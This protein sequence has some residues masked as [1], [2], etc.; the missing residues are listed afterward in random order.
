MRDDFWKN[1]SVLI[2]GHT[3]F[4]GA[5]LSL[6]LN[7]LGAN[8]SGYATEPP[9]NPSLFELASVGI[10]TQSTIADIRDSASLEGVFKSNQPEIV[11]HLAAQSLVRPSYKDPVETFTTNVIGTVNVLE[12]IRN[13]K[14][15][16]AVVIV[17]SDKC[18]ENRQW[19]RGYRE[20]DPLGGYDP[21]SSSKACAELVTASYRCSFF[22]RKDSQAGCPSIASARAGNVI[23]GGDWA[24]DR[25]IPDL[26]RAL[27]DNRSAV[28]RNPLAI[29]PWQHV[30]E[31]LSGYITLAES[32]CDSQSGTDQAWNFGPDEENVRSV[33][34]VCDGMAGR[35][36]DAA[37]WRRDTSQNPH[38]AH[39]LQL[40]SSKARRELG[41]ESILGF[42]EALDW[43]AQWYKGY[44]AGKDARELTLNDIDRYQLRL[45][46]SI[47]AAFI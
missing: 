36:E 43:T 44:M 13:C 20:N 18:Y 21:Y 41:W 8:V 24:A 37:Y 14:S 2:T 27:I 3:G 29:R 40:D 38:E 12:S 1:K 31:P 33:N 35:F 5:W 32:L 45:S 19:A 25:L 4:K 39:L 47:Q 16:K 15:V 34:D 46:R 9:T 30:L 11:F 7:S 6:W 42:E 17:T 23:G 28:I 10:C 26:V 22:N